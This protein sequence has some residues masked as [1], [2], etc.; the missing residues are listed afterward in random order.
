MFIFPFQVIVFGFF[1]IRCEKQIHFFPFFLFLKFFQ[2]T[3]G[4]KAKIVFYFLFYIFNFLIFNFLAAGSIWSSQGQGSDQSCSCELS[5]SS[6]T[7]AIQHRKTQ[8]FNPLYWTREQTCILLLPRCC[9]SCCT[10]VG[11]P[12]ILFWRTDFFFL[13]F[14]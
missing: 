11:A 8:L 3:E 6:S 5:L 12:K 9:P 7:A 10:T 1:I 2:L 14:L 13:P 4:A